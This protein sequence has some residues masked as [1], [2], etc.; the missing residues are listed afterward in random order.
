LPEEGHQVFEDDARADLDAL[1]SRL[2]EARNAVR[3]HLHSG[4]AVRGGG[5]S[6]GGSASLDQAWLDR[7]QD[8]KEA[9]ERALADANDAWATWIADL[10]SG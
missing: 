7:Y 6:T 5:E 10:G 4:I 8:L 9:A 1:E 2:A 3:E